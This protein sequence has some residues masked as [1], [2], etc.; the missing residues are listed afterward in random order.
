MTSSVPD[1]PLKIALIRANVHRR[2]GVE[3]YVLSLANDLSRRGHEVHVF[4]R[5]WEDLLP[6]VIC[7]PVPRIGGL[8][9][10]K[11]L[12]F[13]WG[14]R[15]A[16]RGESFD[17]VHGFDRTLVQ[18]IYRAGEG[19][20]RQ[21]LRV[22]GQYLGP[23][24]GWLR[25]LNPLHFL[26]LFIERRIFGGCRKIVAISRRGQE[27]ILNLYKVPPEDVILI[28]NGVDGQEFSPPQGEDEKASL[29]R[30][31]GISPHDLVLLFVGTGFFRKGFSALLAALRALQ[32]ER[33]EIKLLVAGRGG[34]GY[35]GTVR[36]LGLK[37]AVL[38]LGDTVRTADLYRAADL[39]V[40]PTLYEPFGTACLEALASGLPVIV[41]AMSGASEILTDSVDG[42]ILE[43]PNDPEAIAAKVQLLFDPEVR[44]KMG[45]AARRLSENF[46]VTANTDRTIAVYRTVLES[47]KGG[48]SGAPKEPRGGESPWEE[49]SMSRSGTS[50]A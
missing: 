37:G 49:S 36:R 10:L 45:T 2:G 27:E 14:V 6:T 47:L 16:L 8:S 9:S 44:R 3:R 21:W 18:D 12:S 41:S 34:R 20:H 40:L 50:S 43:D 24:R 39:F 22:S 32:R 25:R 33:P 26:H 46:S 30:S 17:I 35:N 31:L 13:A 19:C 1:L 29:R 5:N 23:L 38:F 28:Y 4:A 42:L 11:V 48:I 15:R 7:H